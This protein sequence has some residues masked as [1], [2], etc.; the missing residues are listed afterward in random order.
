M[1]DQATKRVIDVQGA[2]E[3]N[4]AG[5]DVLLGPGITAVVGVSGSGKSSLAFDTVYNEAR[6]RFMETLALGSPWARVTPARVRRIDGLGPA[7]SIAQNVVNHNPSSTVATAVGAHPF[8]RVL[9]ARGAE[10]TC[11]RCGSPVRAVSREE[12]LRLAMDALRQDDV[13]VEVPV[14]RGL[15]G[16]HQRLLAGL[17]SLF[18][19]IRVDGGPWD[20]AVLAA[21][22]PHDIVVR[23]ARLAQGAATATVRAALAR[24]DGL[25]SAEV[26]VAGRPTLRAP[27]CAGCGEWVPPLEPSAFRS[28]DVDSSSHRIQGLTLDQLLGR[29]TAEVARFVDGLPEEPR[30]QRLHDELGRR[31]RP[32]LALGLDYLTLDR[33]MPTLSRGEAQRVRLAVVLAGRL[34][35][36]LHVLD[37]PTIGL[38]QRDQ[39]RLLDAIAMLPG[40]VVMVE[41]DSTAV[42]LADDVVEIGPG[43]GKA[44][45]HVVFQGTPAQL[46]AAD[47]ASGRGFSAGQPT[48]ASRRVPGDQ[49]LVIRSASA[50]NLTGFDCEIPLGLLTLVTGPSGAGKTTLTRDV[51]MASL[52][53]GR[54]VGCAGLDAPLLRATVVDQSPLG[55]NPRSNPATYTKV[56]DRIRRLFADS[57]GRSASAFTFN[58]AEGAC[59]ECE[60]MGAIEVQ[61][62][63]VA[64]GWI[65]CEA[66]A[67]RRYRPESLE[68]HWDGLSIADVLDLSVDEAAVLFD[69]D[70][71]VA[72]ALEALREV[73]LGYVKLG[74][75]SPSLSGGEA[76]RVRLAVKLARVRPGDLLVL[77][78]PTT[79]LHPADLARLLSVLQR[80]ADQ[81]STVIVVEHHPDVV[82]A[83]DW[84]IDLGPGG[85]PAG[86]R[87]L[88]CGL[89]PATGH[90]AITPRVA[91]RARPRAVDTIRVIGARAHNLQNLDVHFA[92]ERL[93]VVTGVSG[94]GKSSLVHDVLGAEATRRLLECLSVYE[95]QS[96][97]EG[98]EAPVESLTG[99]GPTL[100]LDGARQPRGPRA[101]VGG[102]SELDRLV[103]VLLS[104]AGTR[105]C[106]SCQGPVRRITPAADSPGRCTR[107]GREAPAAEPRHLMGLAAN[108]VCAQCRGLGH[109]R[110]LVESRLIR[111]PSEPICGKCL[112]SPGYY[113]RN[114]LCT[115]GTGGHTS[116]MAFA[117]RYG[118]DPYTTPW[119][120]M[121][122]PARHAFVYGDPKP[123][124]LRFSDGKR[125]LVYAGSAVGDQWW[126]RGAVGVDH[127][128][129][130]LYSEAVECQECSGRRLRPEYLTLRIAGHDRA[131]LFSMPLVALE[132][133]LSG[134][135][136]DDPVAADALRVALRRL[137]F[138]RMIGLGYLHLDRPTWSLSAGEAQRVKLASILGGELRGMTVLLDEPS[139]GLHPSEV[140]A[141]AQ[142][143]Q[144]LR[145][146]GNTVIAVEHDP[147]LIRA[148]DTIIE[149]GP[150][151]GRN[152]GRLVDADGQS[153]LTRALLE[154]RLRATPRTPRRLPAGWMRVVGPRENNLSGGTVRIPLGVLAGV[155]GVSGSG[156]SS[157]VVDTIGLA[158]APP[159]MTT[160]VAWRDRIEPGRHDA[161]EG[162]PG[163][164]V[165]PEPSR[166]AVT[167]V[168][169]YLGVIDALRAAYAASDAAVAAGLTRSDLSHG[170]DA[171][172]GRG[173][174]SERM[175][176]LPPIVRGCE[177]C[178]GTGYRLE[179]AS[180]TLRGLTLPEVERLTLQELE[181][182]E[183]V[184][185][186]GRARDAALRL[187]LGYLAVRQPG[188][189][190][191]GGEMQRLRLARELA[192]KT[193]APS[194]YLLDEPTVG[195]HATD[196][197]R[198]AGALDEVVDAG[199]T[200]LLT[201]HDPHL[202]ACCDW[203]IEL[204]PGAGPDGGRVIF[205]GTPE[206]LAR[207]STP[208]ARYVLEALS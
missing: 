36:L 201:E 97:R 37:E 7:V 171:C 174:W 192:K 49:R 48:A 82:A 52:Q 115:P 17:R 172:N 67:G 161:I 73:G 88:H 191:S 23:V 112:H 47:T 146:A 202:L 164:T 40:P 57:T 18:D 43:G 156:K 179:A 120:Q 162:A 19:A 51:L 135:S 64:P 20:G 85:G 32:L 126:W 141:L 129:G 42:A 3:H 144:E 106:L 60:G 61:L 58:Q 92:K 189:S 206:E 56:F 86:G 103:A 163:R 127:D 128:I 83:A 100:V 95:R 138:L 33:P 180:V 132:R 74:Q 96:A 78:E 117:E 133:A 77:D 72:Q 27:V 194:L 68:A 159:K 130:G 39:E 176:F 30:L 38:H 110:R 173:V 198:L 76:Q 10:V 167:S 35:D 199:H 177:A 87:L 155:C 63:F 24:A 11:P 13:D 6:R 25:G 41:H 84:L 98:P 121:P 44:G 93:T 15:P 66:C 125:E 118:F 31:M 178:G 148:A 197:A 151:P 50:R 71:A 124:D 193:S 29:P 203:L 9:Y 114:Y 175:S 169:S 91:P 75:P 134:T 16:Q 183:A 208:T 140:A 4:L 79:G 108:A 101:S 204:G 12:R 184:P 186:V 65:T 158:L 149:L 99:L 1:A 154:G 109:Q 160:G 147:V 150:G 55:N 8:F 196:V 123:F 137:R 94:S 185:A 104:R 2:A 139:Q 59:P 166:A 131:D 113:P 119:E 181:D 122:Q 187:G 116:L 170:C 80:L 14:V 143:L 188:W 28:A 46:W 195:L 102:A 45:G 168:G 22:Q 81:G 157:L 53:A 107:C 145:S 62:P 136:A 142:A 182:W 26:L 205:E 152:G 105:Q 207:A 153:A 200:V 90:P 21:G 69:A 70:R 165:V 89:P 111:Q 34:E 5:I 190:L 54:P